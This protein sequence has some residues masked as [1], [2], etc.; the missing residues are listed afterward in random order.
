[1]KTE[2]RIGDA[3]AKVYENNV[4]CMVLNGDSLEIL[5]PKEIVDDPKCVSQ[6][7]LALAFSH[8]LNH[9]EKMILAI[10]NKF[11]EYVMEQMPTKTDVIQ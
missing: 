7:H 5:S 11:D 9:E 1:M 8:A 6:V 4:I 3:I 2:I 10:L